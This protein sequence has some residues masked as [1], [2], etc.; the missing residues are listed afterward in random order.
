[1][2]LC[3]NKKIE[4][5]LRAISGNNTCCDCDE[6][7]PQWASVSFGIFMCLECSGRHRALGVHISFVRSVSMDSWNDKQIQMM[8]I[9]GNDKCGGAHVAQ[10]SDPLPGESEAA[11]VARQRQL[12]NEARE[13]MRQKFGSSK[14]LSSSGKMQGIG[15]DPNYGQSKGGDVGLGGLPIPPIDYAQIGE[16]SQKAAQ[17][18]PEQPGAGNNWLGGIWK[19]SRSSSSSSLSLSVPVS[20]GPA[21]SQGGNTPLS[22]TTSPTTGPPIPISSPAKLP[23]ENPSGDDF[24]ANF[25]V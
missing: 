6:K 9:G 17:P 5:E 15:S 12:Q 19:Q 16:A 23:V 7:N 11:Y 13:R 24:F 25:G 20:G 22:S 3:L 10:G 4:A 21:S 2:S 8:R 1:M 18:P 14:G